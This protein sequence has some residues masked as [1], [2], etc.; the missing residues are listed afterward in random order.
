MPPHAR[1][2]QH[3]RSAREPRCSTNPVQLGHRRRKRRIITNNYDPCPP[4]AS[5]DPS[6]PNTVPASGTRSRAGTTPARWAAVDR[7]ETRTL[8]SGVPA[9]T[10]AKSRTADGMMRCGAISPA[11]QRHRRPLSSRPTPPPTTRPGDM[12]CTR[13]HECRHRRTRGGRRLRR[14]SRHAQ[15]TARRPP[16]AERTTPRSAR[17]FRSATKPGR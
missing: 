5:L 4:T 16:K 12:S 6:R 13:D 14:G 7:R 17:T 10:A 8:A 1:G 9:T 11:A 3:P 2:L 15:H